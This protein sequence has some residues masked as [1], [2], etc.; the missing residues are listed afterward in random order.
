MRMIR[1]LLAALAAIAWTFASPALAESRLFSDDAPLKMTITAPFRD[2]IRTAKTKPVPYPATL[3]VTDGAAPA[4]TLAIQIRARGLTR[5]TGGYCDF[6]PLQLAFGDKASVHGTVFKG[7]RKL[8]LVTYCRDF[9]DFE[10]RIML[11]YLAYRLYNVITPVSYRVR[12]AEVTYRKDAGD[13][14]TTRF[15]YVIEEIDDVADRNHSKRLTF[16]SK[17]VTAAQFD[18]H[19]AARAGLFEFMIGN[20]DWDFEA[21]PAGAE[22]CHNARFVAARDTQPLSGVVPIPYDFDY[23][24]F[25]DSPYAGA[26]IGLPVDNVTQRLYRGYCA[27]NGE[28][29]SVVAE[30]RAHRAEMMAVIDNDPRLNPKFRA[31]TDHFMDSFFALLDDPARVQSQIIKPCRVGIADSGRR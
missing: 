11:E 16:A 30:Y 24:G 23:S 13:A 15:G 7:Q 9:N 10:Q 21:G 28:M 26:P 31:K 17:A 19:A 14:G 8:K 3:A 2:L 18:Q 5:R 6:P 29:P 27:S 12:A 4:Q 1:A 22:C 20:L 25:V